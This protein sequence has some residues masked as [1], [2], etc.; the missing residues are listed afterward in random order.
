M[1]GVQRE[2]DIEIQNEANK[3]DKV[4]VRGFGLHFKGNGK[5]QERENNIK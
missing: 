3:V 1:G 2:G 4:S 5:L